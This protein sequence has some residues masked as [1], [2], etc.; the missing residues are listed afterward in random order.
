MQEKV[1]LFYNFTIS[2]FHNFT[3]Y[4]LFTASQCLER[5]TVVL[6]LCAEGVVA[7]HAAA[8]DF[9]LYG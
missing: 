5:R 3:I 9:T 4:L 7:V 2:Q 6:Q 1:T 8:D